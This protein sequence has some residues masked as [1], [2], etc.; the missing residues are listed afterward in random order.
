MLV[1]NLRTCIVLAALSI[2]LCGDGR[3]E[4]LRPQVAVPT[5]G[6]VPRDAIVF[7]IS[8]A[9]RGADL[10]GREDATEILQRAL[11]ELKSKGGGTLFL[12]AGRYRLEKS[13]RIDGGV[14]LRGEWAKPGSAAGTKGT[15]L[16]VFGGRGE[17]GP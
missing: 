5:P 6:I 17:E 13:L 9:E 16:C 3:A 1:K 4:G 8:A 12:P 10:T 2:A 7:S 11:D 15:I 14:A